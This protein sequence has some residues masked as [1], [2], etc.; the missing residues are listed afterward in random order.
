[1]PSNP[2]FYF[3]LALGFALFGFGWMLF[4]WGVKAVGFVLGFIFGYSMYNLLQSLLPIFEIDPGQYM[5]DNPWVIVGFAA[6]WGVVGAL[7]SKRVYT[8]MVF[9]GVL[10]GLLY[11]LY[12]DAQ[13]MG[14]LRGFLDEVGVLS[15]LDRVLG[16]VWPALLAFIIAI[17]VIYFEKQ[18]IILITACAGSYLIASATAPILFLP[19]CFIGYLLQQKQKPLKKADD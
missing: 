12:T 6:V 14:Y 9:V 16:N 13:Q 8:A 10:A 1:M 7:L 19:L 3:E 5:P 17:L 15:H 11:I 4:R 18:V 2:N